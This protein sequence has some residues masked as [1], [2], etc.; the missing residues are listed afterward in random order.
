[1]HATL[2]AIETPLTLVQTHIPTLE[3]VYLEIMG[4]A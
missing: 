1:M 2:K 4:E 3:E